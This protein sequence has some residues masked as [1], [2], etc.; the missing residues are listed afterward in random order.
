VE[1]TGFS[2]LIYNENKFKELRTLKI[3]E[4][5]DYQLETIKLLTIKKYRLRLSKGDVVRYALKALALKME[6]LLEAE[7]NESK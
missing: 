6:I 4:D 5:A 7:Q 1:K 3:S 2:L